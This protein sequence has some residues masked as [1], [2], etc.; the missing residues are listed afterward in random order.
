MFIK[1]LVE[2]PVF[3]GELLSEINPQPRN[4]KELKH[5]K[6]EKNHAK[7]EHNQIALKNTVYVKE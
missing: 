2:S 1:N 4:L 5:K 6:H 7:A 3:E